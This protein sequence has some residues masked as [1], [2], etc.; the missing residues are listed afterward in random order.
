VAI[1]KLSKKGEYALRA[2]S[3]LVRHWGQ[4]PVVIRVIA[5]EEQIPRKFLEQILLELRR[6]GLVESTRGA[7]GGYR[8][9]KDPETVSVARV[10]RLIDGPLAPLRCVSRTA[11]IRCPREEGCGLRLVMGEVREA[12]ADIL[13]A[14]TL[15]DIA[16]R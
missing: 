2:L 10:V 7:A 4:G 3:C 15:A 16:G 9:L 12:I 1:V 11:L 5:D 13:E 14:R 6:D 8:L